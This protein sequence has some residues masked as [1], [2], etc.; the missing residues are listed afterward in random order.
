MSEAF[1]LELRI[2][3]SIISWLRNSVILI[4]LSISLKSLGR[5]DKSI[6]LVSNLAILLSLCI[7]IY[8]YQKIS[9]TEKHFKNTYKIKNFIF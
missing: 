7:L 9:K 3:N 5:E 4:A 1:V 2:E 8:L 6:Y